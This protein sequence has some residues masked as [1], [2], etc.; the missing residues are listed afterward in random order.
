MCRLPKF[1]S[2][3]LGEWR[4]LQLS[5][6]KQNGGSEGPYCDS[7]T[8]R[9][10]NSM[11]LAGAKSNSSQSN[12]LSSNG[13]MKVLLLKDPKT[14]ELAADPYVKEFSSHGL[15]AALIP[16]L[17]FAFVSLE[18]FFK[19]LSHPENYD[20]LIF[21][22]PRAVE[23]VKLCLETA[24]NKEAWETLLREKWNSKP[25]YVVGKATSA[26]VDE[27][28]LSS[29]GEGSGNAENLADYIFSKQTSYSAPILF[30]CGS[31]KREVLPKRLHENQVPLETITVY[32]TAQH[33]NLQAA[34]EDYFAKEGIPA[35]IV[36]FSPSGVKF[37][38]QFLQKLS[39]DQLHNIKFAAIGSTTAEAMVAEGIHVSCTAQTP[40]P[41]DLAMGIKIM[42]Q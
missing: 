36:F 17:S 35:S 32:Q 11:K 12:S 33:P 3:Q 30:P 13:T 29:E 28:G 25:I 34:L 19:K 4:A 24:G 38:L 23:A 31:L 7:P 20:S 8:L 26:L 18:C 5:P 1:S 39:S 2:C 15:E 16:V 10:P 27:V 40:T 21:T 42:Q 14:S 41:K 9:C 22:S 6:R 37:C